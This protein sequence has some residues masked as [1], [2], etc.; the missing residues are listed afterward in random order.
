MLSARRRRRLAHCPRPR[1]FVRFCYQRR[2]VGWP[3]LYDEM[4]AVATRGL[5]RGMDYDA[6]AEIGVRL[7]PVRD[8]AAGGA[9]RARRRRGAGGRR[10]AEAARDR[11]GAGAAS[12]AVSRGRLALE[13][14]LRRGCC[15]R[16]IS[17]SIWRSAST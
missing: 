5:Y 10:A 4:C 8:A 11:A 6:L 15:R 3:E 2:R 7:Q 9:R 16:A 12:A 1:R 13:A 17:P 14:R